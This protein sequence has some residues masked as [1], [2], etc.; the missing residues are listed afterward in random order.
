MWLTE[1]F[2]KRATRG[3]FV[4]G[5]MFLGSAIHLG[6]EQAWAIFHLGIGFACV[7]VGIAFYSLRLRHRATQPG[8]SATLQGANDAV[9]EN[10]APTR[11]RLQLLRSN[12]DSGG[13]R[14]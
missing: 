3:T 13:A 11:F 14:Q 9:V 6:L 4:L 5:L 12:S 7:G 2:C 1:R 10:V 8:A